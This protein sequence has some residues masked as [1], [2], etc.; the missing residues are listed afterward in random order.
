[1][2]KNNFGFNSS[3]EF[4]QVMWMTNSATVD[5]ITTDVVHFIP[6]DKGHPVLQFPRA[7][8]YKSRPTRG[9]FRC[10]VISSVCP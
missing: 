7:N 1:M 5:K 4:G 2:N 10:T 9:H 6:G 8:A 3:M